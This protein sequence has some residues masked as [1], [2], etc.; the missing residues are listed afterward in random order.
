[1]AT[2]TYHSHLLDQQKQ[3]LDF[4]LAGKATFT[5]KSLKTGKHF[6]FKV[7]VPKDK[8][9]KKDT[10]SPIYFVSVMTGPDNV[11]SYTY[12]GCIKANGNTKTYT[13]SPKSRINAAAESAQAF[14][15]IFGFLTAGKTCSALELWHEGRCCRCG[16]KLTTPE[17]VQLGIGPECLTYREKAT[18]TPAK[19][20]VYL[21]N[22]KNGE[23]LKLPQR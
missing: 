23:S 5:A 6:T 11:S 20:P 13:H 14:A 3:A 19:R 4:I 10:G 1:M 16:R 9:D 22:S 8:A 18:K 12:L 15:F 21:V 7:E 2:Q 17:S